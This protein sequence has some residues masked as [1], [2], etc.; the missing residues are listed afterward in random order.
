MKSLLFALAS[1]FAASVATAQTAA[2]LP[3][4]PLQLDSF[5][6]GSATG[7][8]LAGTTWVGQVT[9]NAT[10]I[11]VGGSA[12]DD[13]GWGV[14]GTNINGVGYTYL[15]VTAQRAVGNV[16]SSFAIQ[17]EDQNLN[18]QVISVSTSLF[19]TASMTTV[20]VPFAWGGGFDP[21]SIGGWSIGGGSAGIFAFQMTLDYL[22]L[23][24]VASIPEPSTIALLGLGLALVGFTVVR[25]KRAA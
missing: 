16:A 23:D 20:S 24:T 17:F 18:T 1:L 10:S 14:T 8:T 9:Q 19:D 22:G 2:I 13:N 25:R 15:V 21:S 6:T 12:K 7:S 11:T 3:L 5:N 4:S